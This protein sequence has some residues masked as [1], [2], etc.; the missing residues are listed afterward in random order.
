MVH[1]TMTSRLLR[2]P[3]ELRSHIYEYVISIPDDNRPTELSAATAPSKALLLVNHQVY[4]ECRLIYRDVLRKYWQTTRFV[5]NIPP[6]L[7][8]KDIRQQ[9]LLHQEDDLQHVR[10][11]MVDFQQE[12]RPAG[13]W[14][15]FKMTLIDSVGVWMIEA[16]THQRAVPAK[17]WVL[18][19]TLEGKARLAEAC[20]S[21]DVARIESTKQSGNPSAVSQQISLLLGS[22]QCVQEMSD[23]R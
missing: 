4:N 11:L 6:N 21:A 18:A 20:D 22:L 3:A 17:Y 7:S 1:A 5:I 14:R 23:Q 13:T 8:A 2:L 9:I 16:A 15:S 19:Q 12:L 10:S